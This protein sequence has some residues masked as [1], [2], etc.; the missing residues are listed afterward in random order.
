[1]WSSKLPRL[2]TSSDWQSW[3]L[4]PGLGTE[5]I[6]CGGNSD[7]GLAGGR[8]VLGQAPK[9]ASLGA[10]IPWEALPWMGSP[11]LL[12]CC[13][14]A[15]ESCQGPA[16]GSPSLFKSLLGGRQ[17]Y[18]MRG[19]ALENKPSAMFSGGGPDDHPLR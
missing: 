9:T 13:Q 16:L 19:P 5:L 8:S 4:S 11:G 14:V 10:L 1:M 3:G 12:S 2:V 18:L 6:L 17:A 7:A 15:Q